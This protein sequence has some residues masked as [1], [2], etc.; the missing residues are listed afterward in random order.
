MKE[1]S[2]IVK[3]QFNNFSCYNFLRANKISIEIIKKV[4]YGGIFINDILLTNINIKLKVK[5]IVKIVLPEDKINEFIT[6]KKGNLNVVYEDDFLLVINKEKGVLTHSLKN[7]NSPSLEEIFYS[8]YNFTF[9]P[10]NRLDK[11]TSGLLLIA[12]DA[13]TASFLGEQIKNGL[14]KKTYHCLVEKKPKKRHFIIEKPISRLENSIIKRCVSNDGDYAKTEVK[15]VK[16][17]KGGLSLLK[18]NLLTGRTHQIRVHLSYAGLPL[19]ADS[20]YGEKVENKTYSLIASKLE[21]LH[22]HTKK[23]IKVK[24]NIKGC[25]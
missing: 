15:F 20:L 13:L 1:F 24:L 25:F 18:V 11:D 21:F 5:D 4:K 6:P 14:I 2:F 7:N 17:L 22:P 8:F 3:K 19:Y 12:K 23:K 9:R 16:K 10:I